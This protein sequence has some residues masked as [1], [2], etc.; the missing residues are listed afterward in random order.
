MHTPEFLY[1]VVG[2]ISA[3]Q[4]GGIYTLNQP[5][6]GI[7]WRVLGIG[8]APNYFSVDSTS[9]IVRVTRPLTDD[10]SEFYSLQVSLW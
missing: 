1:L 3:G 8:K 2:R 4:T 6:S 7:T 9:G 10:N 5:V